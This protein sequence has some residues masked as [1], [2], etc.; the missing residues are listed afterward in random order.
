MSNNNDKQILIEWFPIEFDKTLLK[1]E[2]EKNN[3]IITLK[4]ILQ[5][6]DTINQNGR[7]YPKIILERELRN[8][9]KFIQ[10]RRSLG[11]CVDKETLIHTKK[12]GY[13][14][15]KDVKVGDIV[16]TINLETNKI[17]EQPVLEKIEKHFSG[18]MIGIESKRVSMLLT[19]NHKMIVYDIFEK[20]YTIF[21]KDFYEKTLEEKLKYKINNI[22]TNLI[23]N[24]KENG[25][26]INFSQIDYDDMVY[27]VTTENKNFIAK[28]DKESFLTHNCDHP[29]DSSVVEL[30]NVS[31][32]ITSAYMEGG[33]VYGTI[34]ILDTPS[35][36]IVRSLIEAGVTLGISSRGVGST[37]KQDGNDVVQDDFQLICWDLVSEPSTPGAF[38]MKESK[39]N[40]KNLNKV[41]NKSDRINRVMNDIID[42]S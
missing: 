30:K 36:K 37:K 28:R 35:G 27:C 10:E 22:S 39:L 16:F 1:E 19:P 17:E 2:S 34:E 31:H 6:A 25:D 7:I 33:I 5:K 3:G 4:G 12:N 15:I 26:E 9:Q 18:K 42:W 40:N 23:F 21:A 41:F 24:V 38:M 14:P 8:Y 13:I 29:A 20:P 11:E 32:L